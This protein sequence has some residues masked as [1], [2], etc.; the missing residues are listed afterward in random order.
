MAAKLAPPAL[1]SFASKSAPVLGPPT[2]MPWKRALSVAG[3]G[4]RA[5][6]RSEDPRATLSFRLHRD[7]PRIRRHHSARRGVP[8]HVMEALKRLRDSGRR[9]CSLP[10][11][12]ST[13][14]S[15]SS[16][17]SASS[18]AW[19]PRRRDPLPPHDGSRKEL[20]DPAPEAMVEMLR[21]GGI[22]LSGA[23]HRRHRPPARD[24]VRRLIATW[25]SSTGDLQQGRGHGAAPSC[26]KGERAQGRARRARAL[27]RNVVACGDGENDHAL[28]TWPSTRCDRQCGAEPQ[29][30]RRWVTTATTRGCVLEVVAD[31]IEDRPRAPGARRRRRALCIGRDRNGE[32][33]VFPA[34]A[35]R[36][37]S[38]GSHAARAPWARRCSSASPR[39]ATSSACSTPGRLPRLRARRGFGTSP[40][41]RGRREVLT[42]MQSRR[43]GGGLPGRRPARARQEFVRAATPS[44]AQAA[45]RYRA[46]H[47]IC[48]RGADLMPASSADDDSPPRRGENHLR[49]LRTPRR[50]PPASSQRGRHRGLR[51][52]RA[53]D[54]DA[55]AGQRSR[56]APPRCPPRRRARGEALLWF[57]KSNRRWRSSTSWFKASPAT[58]RKRPRERARR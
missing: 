6:C 7:S 56:G 18:T 34:G 43:A 2:S 29:G 19:W 51:R 41:R 9:W 11:G 36:C 12:S 52:Q 42:A 32:G 40:I 44:A 15:R 49:D 13:S 20:G 10:A 4:L 38:P 24:T 57:R 39:R 58:R 47:W 53:R 26:N 45:R 46:P 37:S 30:G 48:R 28:L 22:P 16:R 50:S 21:A 27:S 14:C 35:R 25:A 23:T 8:P 31:M 5:G 55:F 54:H 17:E 1:R 3:P 33:V